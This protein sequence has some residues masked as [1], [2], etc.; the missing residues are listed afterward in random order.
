MTG[1][2]MVYP[3]K[4]DFIHETNFKYFSLPGSDPGICAEGDGICGGGVA[5]RYLDLGG[6]RNF[7]GYQFRCSSV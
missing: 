4:K 3:A 5:V 7:D 6:R 2:V 1:P